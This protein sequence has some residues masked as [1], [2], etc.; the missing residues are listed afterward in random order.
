ME[1]ISAPDASTNLKR[2]NFK[3]R[4]KTKP[5]SVDFKPK[6]IYKKPLFGCQISGPK[7]R[8][9]AERK[10]GRRKFVKVKTINF[11]VTLICTSFVI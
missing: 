8:N 3:P 2:I 11:N 9:L 10:E 5:L 6:Y 1:P 7:I 4:P